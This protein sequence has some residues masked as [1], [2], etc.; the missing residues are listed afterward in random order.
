VN[1]VTHRVY[2]VGGFTKVV[3]PGAVAPPPPVVTAASVN[4]QGMWWGANGAESG[5][6]IDIAQQGDLVFA[7]WF[8]YD[9]TGNAQWFVMPRG[10]RT[11]GDEYMGTLYRVSGPAFTAAFDPA[12]VSSTAVGSMVL[13]FSDANTGTLDAIV[14]NARIVK[15]ITR[16]VFASPA[17]T[18]TA[19]GLGGAAPNYT[20]I[21]WKAPPD[22]NRAGASSSRTRAT[23]SSPSGSRSTPTGAPRGSWAPT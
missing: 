11:S 8:T 4:A 14:G 12:R 23:T 13:R 2:T 16:Q 17:P 5:W 6:G 20:D 10:D 15:P 7:A 18:C 3:D 1:P 19:G 22:P 21:W 9:E